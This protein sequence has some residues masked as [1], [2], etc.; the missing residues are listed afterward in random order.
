MKYAVRVM[1]HMTAGELVHRSR[2]GVKE[3]TRDREMLGWIDRF[4]YTNVELLAIRFGVAPQN[5]RVRLKRLEAGGLV[6]LQRR[7]I[8]EPWVVSVTA[9]GARAIGQTPRPAPRVD[10]HQAHELAIG[11]LCARL[12]TSERASGS[13]VLTEREMRRR[14]RN[15]RREGLGPRYAL[16]LPGMPRGQRTR[17]PDLVINAHGEPVRALELEFTQKSDQRL[18]AIIDAYLLGPFPDVVYLTAD[19]NLTGKLARVI[20]SCRHGL[21]A[22]DSQVNVRVVPWPRASAAT[23]ALIRA[24]MQAYEQAD[25]LDV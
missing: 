14:E 6:R 19:P 2:G 10:I 18:E 24:R 16:E 4:R 13:T 17:W 22:L 15:R 20:T 9:A 21:L 12:E 23:Q 1:S 11:W 8:T 25:T 7:S 3:A 5:V